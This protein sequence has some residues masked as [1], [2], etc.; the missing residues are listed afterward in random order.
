M[1]LIDRILF[2]LK[3]FIRDFKFQKRLFLSFFSPTFAVNLS[4]PAFVFCRKNVGFY[5]HFF[6]YI[7]NDSLCGLIFHIIFVNIHGSRMEHILWLSEPV[8]S[9]WYFP[10]LICFSSGVECLP[11]ITIFFRQFFVDYLNIF[12]IYCSFMYSAYVCDIY[13]IF[14][15]V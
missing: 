4:P 11:Y 6:C 2:S 7:F 8:Q 15:L 12:D 9:Y 14:W 3:T 5:I 13:F 10:L 1:R